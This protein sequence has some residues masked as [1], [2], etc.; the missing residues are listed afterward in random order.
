MK[1][2]KCKKMIIDGSKAPAK[3]GTFKDISLFGSF[4]FPLTGQYKGG[5]IAKSLDGQGK[6]VSK[7][8]A[9]VDSLSSQTL[10]IAGATGASVTEDIWE[11]S[12]TTVDG[13]VVQNELYSVKF[14]QLSSAT[15]E[16]AVLSPRA[17]ASGNDDLRPR[18][19]TP[20]LDLP[21]KKVGLR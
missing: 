20:Y 15:P 10:P 18:P 6:C 14:I 1:N 4:V 11:P 8:K 9:Q 17:E 13:Q 16:D 2:V 21:L 7:T 3:I 19:Q 5:I 12:D